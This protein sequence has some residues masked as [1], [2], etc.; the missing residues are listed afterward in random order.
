MPRH[1]NVYFF[2]REVSYRR[3]LTS[4]G[5]VLT[6]VV[7]LIPSTQFAFLLLEDGVTSITVQSIIIAAFSGGAIVGGLGYALLQQRLGPATTFRLAIAVNAA[8][9]VILG[10]VRAPV[11]LATG[12]ALLGLACGTYLPFLGQSLIGAA[13]MAIRTHALGLFTTFNY[14]GVAI[15]PV[16]LAP[17]R[18][19]L[20]LRG[21]FIA[22]GAATG[23]ALAIHMIAS[24]SN[25]HRKAVLA[26][27]LR[28]ARDGRA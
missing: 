21:A 2:D 19:A 26:Q 11:A 20:G 7:G 18:L 22:L 24:I 6:M 23:L 16:I 1:V 17:L 13:A 25:T 5:P 12:S 14:I 15:S 8:A 10:L 3:A 28:T 4:I 9:F 27:G